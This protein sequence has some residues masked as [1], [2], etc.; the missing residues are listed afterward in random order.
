LAVEAVHRRRRGEARWIR[1]RTRW[2]RPTRPW[3]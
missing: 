3:I 2:I 1:Y